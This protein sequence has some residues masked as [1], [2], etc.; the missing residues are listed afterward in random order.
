MTK[1]EKKPVPLR[2]KLGWTTLRPGSQNC[3]FLDLT[4]DEVGPNGVSINLDK[5]FDDQAQWNYLEGL[6][7]QKLD[8]ETIDRVKIAHDRLPRLFKQIKT[9]TKITYPFKYDCLTGE[10]LHKELEAS[11]RKDITKG[12]GKARATGFAIP[13]LGRLPKEYTDAYLIKCKIQMALRLLDLG[14][15]CSLR[16]CIGKPC[17]GVRPLTV[18]H[19]DNVYL[20]GFAQQVLQKEIARLQILPENLCSYQRGKGCNNATIVDGVV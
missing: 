5:T 11:L 10:Y 12:N 13:V 16:I 15:E 3:H 1:N 2:T 7:Q 6:I 8:Y 9:D 20:N 4:E 14:T 19:D 18:S 17:G